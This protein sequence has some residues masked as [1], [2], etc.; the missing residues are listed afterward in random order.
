[1]TSTMNRGFTTVNAGCTPGSRANTNAA[2][3]GRRLSGDGA[4][5]AAPER[6]FLGLFW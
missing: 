2:S 6:R 4:I 5:V 3:L 1:M